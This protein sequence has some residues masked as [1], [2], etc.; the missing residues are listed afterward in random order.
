MMKQFTPKHK[1][2][3]AIGDTVKTDTGWTFKVEYIH[4]PTIDLQETTWMYYEL[5]GNGADEDRLTHQ[6]NNE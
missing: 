5:S 1:P 4:R 2:K 3:F 6:N